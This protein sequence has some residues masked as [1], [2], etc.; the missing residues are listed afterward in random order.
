[1]VA[2]FV[3]RRVRQVF[4]A[5]SRDDYGAV[6]PG[7]APDVHHRFAGD[8]PLGG[9]RHDRAALE[10]WFERLFRLFPTL[11]FSIGAIGVSG[12]WWDLRASVPWQSEVTP[13]HGP[14][15]RNVGVHLLRLRWGR[16]VEIHAY[17]DSQAVARACATM[18]AA[19]IEE[20]GAPPIV[21]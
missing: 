7:V 3:R 8:H 18:L 21:S 16:V 15:Y 10:A 2:W 4:A 14:D 12:P 17:E 11:T 1:M 13:A 20:A 9:E 6:L 5:L 19:G